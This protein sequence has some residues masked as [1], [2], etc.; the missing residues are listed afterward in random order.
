MQRDIQHQLSSGVHS[1]Q[2]HARLPEGTYEEEY[3]RDGFFGPATHI[4]HKHPPTAWTRIEGPLRPRAFYLDQ[5]AEANPDRRVPVLNNAACTVSMWSVANSMD[6]LFRNGDGDELLFVHKGAGQM[7]TELG[8]L[9]FGE[10]DYLVVPRGIGYQL[11]L[12]QPATILVV[13]AT[14]GRFMLPDRGLLGPHAIFDPA[15]LE[16][17]VPEG[18]QATPNSAGEYEVRVKRGGRLSHVF[19]PHDPTDI[20]GWKGD[21]TVY[22]LNWRDIRP[23]VSHRYHVPPSAH[24]TFMA[25]RFVVC[26]FVPR[27]FESDPDALKVPFFHRNIDFDE[28]IFLHQGNFMSRDNARPAMATLHPAGIHH[29]PHPKALANQGKVPMA[30]EVAVMVDFRDAVDVSAQSEAC[31]LTE[32]VNS[33]QGYLNGK[34]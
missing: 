27:P 24:T 1:R 29:G 13:E 16:T 18:C 28:F 7:M 14:G 10:G 15:M 22:R 31:E 34:H 2:A 17:P 33:W 8:R 23:V 6:H 12:E 4:Y 32:Y 3:G 5:L 26:T 30:E 20:A 21:T 19:Y 9:S 25:D 11:R